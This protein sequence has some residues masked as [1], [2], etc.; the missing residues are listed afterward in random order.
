[1]PFEDDIEEPALLKHLNFRQY[2]AMG[3]KHG[4]IQFVPVYF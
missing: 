3:K 1:M 4:G 2:A